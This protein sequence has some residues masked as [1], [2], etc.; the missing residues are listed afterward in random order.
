MPKCFPLEISNVLLMF[1]SIRFVSTIVD[2]FQSL[3]E[4]FGISQLSTR[5]RWIR[6]SVP[7]SINKPLP[8]RVEVR[9]CPLSPC[10]LGARES[11]VEVVYHAPVVHDDESLI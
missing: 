1:L 10:Q 2:E 11:P 6:A 5:D 4:I 7:R 3:F 8:A 9:L